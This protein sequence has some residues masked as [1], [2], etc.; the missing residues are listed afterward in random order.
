MYSIG[1]RVEIVDVNDNYHMRGLE[2]GDRGWVIL[3][4]REHDVAVM[5]DKEFRGGLNFVAEENS[6][7]EVIRRGLVHAGEHVQN[8]SAWVRVEDLELC[9]DHEIQ[10]IE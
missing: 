10:W 6:D 2:I 1:T 9:S 4:P 8:R 5:F 3:E 7:E